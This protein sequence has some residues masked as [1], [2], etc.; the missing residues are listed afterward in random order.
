MTDPSTSFR[1][2]YAYVSIAAILWAVSGSASKYLF[3]NGLSPVQVVQLRT[4]IAFV[5][6]LIWLGFRHPSLLRISPGDSIYFLVLG[7]FGI[8]AAQFFYLFAI[9]K[10]NVA[11][12]ILLHYTGPVFVTLY[13]IVFTHYKLRPAAAMAI[14]GTLTGCFLVVGAYNIELLEVNSAGIFGGLLAAVA[15]AT[16]SLLSEYGMRKY[17]PWTVLFYAMLSAALIWNLIHFPLEAFLHSYSPV[18]WGW[19]LFIGGLGTIV[20][21]G[22]YF[23]GIN[24]IRSTHASITATLEPITAGALSFLFLKETMGPLQ[25]L[26]AVLVIASIILLQYKQDMDENAPGVIRSKRAKK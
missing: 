12:A 10:I 19:I 21:F 9:S 25:I 11:A 24:L 2:G 18:V 3:N 14:L 26:G 5:G 6:L 7:I 22:L 17:N 20:P 13:S 1:R 8:A 23:E 4:T 16:Y 15:F